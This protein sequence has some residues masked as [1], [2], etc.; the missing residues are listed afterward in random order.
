MTEDKDSLISKQA[1]AISV[2]IVYACFL[3]SRAHVLY[4]GHMQDWKINTDYTHAIGSIS[5]YSD[6]LQKCMMLIIKK[7]KRRDV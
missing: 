4:M 3:S 5:K 1:L 2:P 7:S 6:T